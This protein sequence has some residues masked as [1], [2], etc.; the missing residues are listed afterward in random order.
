LQD[1]WTAERVV[2]SGLLFAAFRAGEVV[3]LRSLGLP[4]ALCLG[5]QRLGLD[6]LRSLDEGFAFTEFWPAAREGRAPPPRKA[7][8]EENEAVPPSYHPALTIRPLLVLVGWSPL[9]LSPVVSPLLHRTAAYLARVRRH[10]GLQLGGVMVWWP[11][12]QHLENLR[13]RLSLGSQELVRE[14]LLES[15]DELYDFEHFTGP[16]TLPSSPPDPANLAD[17]R[18]ELLR[19]LAADRGSGPRSRLVSAA[20]AKY[21][22]LVDAKLVQPLRDWAGK[23]G[24]PVTRSAAEELASVAALLHEMGPTMQELVRGQLENDSTGETEAKMP[25]QLDQFLE[26]VRHHGALMRDLKCWDKWI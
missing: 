4:A 1:H 21:S 2:Q 19:Q 16:E 3:W 24:H 6:Q 15:S 26:L 13:F 14:L 23:N 9:A 17:A 5:L 22:A 18:A 10:L 7:V 12:A 8:Y 20:Q 25:V 11:R